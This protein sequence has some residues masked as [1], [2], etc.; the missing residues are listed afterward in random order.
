MIGYIFLVNIENPVFGFSK[1]LG[2]NIR[3]TNLMVA[4][5]FLI[6]SIPVF[7]GIRESKKKINLSFNNLWIDS[8]GRIQS[9]FKSI[10]EYKEL[11]KFLIARLFYNDGLW[12]LLLN[13]FIQF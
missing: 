13:G 5:W 12:S 1:D 4:I 11:V 8:F 9:T 6:F 2:E 3:A 7:L 10:S